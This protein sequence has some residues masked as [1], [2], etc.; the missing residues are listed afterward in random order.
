[1]ITLWARTGTA[2]CLRS[3]SRVVSRRFL[4]SRHGHCGVARAQHTNASTRAAPGNSDSTSISPEHWKS[5]YR[6]FLLHVHPDFFHDQPKERAVNEKS[7]KVL[8]MHLDEPGD[9]PASNGACLVFFFKTTT[10]VIDYTTAHDHSNDGHS[11]ASVDPKDEERRSPRKVMLPIASDRNSTKVEVRHLLN[12]TG[13]SPTPVPSPSLPPPKPSRHQKPRSAPTGPDRD[14]PGWND[15]GK[16]FFGETP[17]NRAWDE[18][19]ARAGRG[20][21][22]DGDTTSE[23]RQ[24]TT[25]GGSASE[26]YEHSGG[27]GLGRIVATDAGR[28]LVRERRVSARNVRRLVEELREKHGFGKFTFRRVCTRQDVDVSVRNMYK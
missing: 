11:Y 20:R 15:W 21:G 10:A 26:E 18:A 8:S 24:R 19:A 27:A 6:A 23:G 28:A 7:L 25:G 2:R 5:V 14:S 3:H 22:Q 16:Y 17:A 13:V 12:V 1:M 9:C 4:G